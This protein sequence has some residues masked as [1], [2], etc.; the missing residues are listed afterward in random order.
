[1]NPSHDMTRSKR[2]GGRESRE[3][4]HAPPSERCVRERGR[5]LRGG[6][7][8]TI[9]FSFVRESGRELSGCWNMTAW[10]VREVREGGREERG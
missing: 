5:E 4:R 8:F 6:E 3:P 9:S 1:L 7:E 10:K 2:E